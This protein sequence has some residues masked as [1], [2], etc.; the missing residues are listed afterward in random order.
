MISV[1][2]VDDQELV[3]AGLRSVLSSA[4]DLNVVAEAENGRQAVR[5]AHELEQLDV[6]LLDI[7]MPVLDGLTALPQI[8][9]IRPDLAVLILT[10]FQDDEYVVAALAQGASGFLLKRASGTELIAAV[11]AG[12]AGDAVLAPEVTRAV[13]HRSTQ[14]APAPAPAQ[15]PAELTAR[16][17]DVFRMITAGA[18]NAEIAAQLFLSDST[19]K[20]HVSRVLQKLGC[21]DR[22]QVALLG[23]RM[24][25]LAT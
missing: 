18:N 2:V 4:A 13:I 22:V 9:E 10:T 17:L 12:A 19:V 23:V 7:R 20:T 14:P 15:T 25:I 1:A 3:R 5:L 16:E 21:R 8:L 6:M 11:R 24:N